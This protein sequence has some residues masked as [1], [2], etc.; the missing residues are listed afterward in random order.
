MLILAFD[1]SG[2]C[3]S[4]ALVAG[5]Q[6]LAEEPLD[7]SRRFAQTLV[8]EIDRLLK[9]HGVSP[10]QIG[11]VAT[12]I[13]P[14]SF[15]GL[16][17]AVTTAKTFAYAT[18]AA[19]VG[20]S[21]LEAI[22][23]GVPEGLFNDEPHEVQAIVDAQRREFFAARFIRWDKSACEGGTLP[24]RR[25]SADVLVAADAWLADLTPGTI[26][27]GPAV[28]PLEPRLPAGVLLAPPA[29]RNVRAAIV[30]QLAWRDYQAGR[31]DDLWKL[32]PKYLRPSYA[33]EKAAKHQ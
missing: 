23:A 13:G 22:A 11:L 16:R 21:T 27:T 8:P 7:P 30:G 28:A 15:T 20:L 10:S 29:A 6:L 1:T 33:E 26:V 2:A 25:L 5:G 17:L 24:L 4:I 3:G 12:T 14:G 18:G 32:A 31:R 19:V 9:R